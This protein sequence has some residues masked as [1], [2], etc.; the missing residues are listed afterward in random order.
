MLLDLLSV[1]SP[2]GAWTRFW[3]RP[4]WSEEESCT[5]VLDTGA[6]A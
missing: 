4:S 1:P 5:F 2:G 3:G 6:H